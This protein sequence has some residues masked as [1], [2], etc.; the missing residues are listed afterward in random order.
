MKQFVPNYEMAAKRLRS[1]STADIEVSNIYLS[2]IGLV[3][4][5]GYVETR[6]ERSDYVINDTEQRSVSNYEM[7]DIEDI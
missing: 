4:I 3:S 5:S 6:P 7:A 2:A 1:P